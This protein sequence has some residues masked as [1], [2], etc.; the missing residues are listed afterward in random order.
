MMIPYR[1][2][3][4]LVEHLEHRDRPGELV[5]ATPEEVGVPVGVLEDL[6]VLAVEGFKEPGPHLRAPGDR[7]GHQLED[8]SMGEGHLGEGAPAHE[9]GHV[10]ATA[11]PGSR[12]R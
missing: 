7:E 9:E 6:E 12:R 1:L 10:A 5:G 2:R 4:G 11:P 8:G 3:R